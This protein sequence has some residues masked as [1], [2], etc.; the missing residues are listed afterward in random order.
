M[1]E[2]LIATRS[3][4]KLRE[5]APMLS[6][7]GFRAITLGDAGIAE[8]QAENDLEVFETFEENA[9]AK[10]NWF[11]FLGGG[12]PVIADDSGLTVDALGG[13]PGVRSKRWSGRED[14]EGQALDDVNNE[15][16]VRTLNERALPQPWNAQYVCAAVC[17]W[18]TGSS[19]A[20]GE[21]AG[22]ILQHPRG[23]GGFGYDPYF[24]SAEL[25]RTFGESTREAKAEVSHRGRA[26]RSLVQMLKADPRWNSFCS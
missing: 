8:Q 21:C 11:F 9:I 17:V 24:R 23:T 18:P 16:L 10:A 22:E 13:Q 12:R 20:R 1:R 26:V 15:L 6:E 5:L 2:L 14:V 25:G 3:E 4:G 7:L 19:A